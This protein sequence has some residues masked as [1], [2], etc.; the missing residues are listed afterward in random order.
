MAYEDH[1]YGCQRSDR[2][3]ARRHVDGRRTRGGRGITQFGCRRA[4]RRGSCR[5]AGRAP[6]RSSTSRIPRRSKTIRS[7]SSSRNRP[8]M[9]LPPR[10]PRGSATMSC[11]RS[12]AL[13]GLPDSGYMR[14]KVAQEKL[15]TESGLPYSIVR[16]TQFSE[17]A[18]AI[19]ASMTVGDE[20]RV[21][22][23]LIQPITADRVAS[24]VARAAVANP[25]NG[26]REHRWAGRRSRSSRW[27][28]SHWPARVTTRRPSSS[29]PRPATSARRCGAT[30]S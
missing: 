18:D 22:D 16:A 9:W 5:S 3:Q 10:R 7:W 17:F 20:V 4:H 28:A 25:L 21:P 2:H 14:A 6:T 11:C 27:H 26:C 8:R 12:S 24:D 19:T 23:A 1:G 15:L 29:T 13:D 30:A